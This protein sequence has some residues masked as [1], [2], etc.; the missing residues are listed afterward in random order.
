MQDGVGEVGE[1]K[2]KESSQGTF[3]FE[4]MTYD[5]ELFSIESGY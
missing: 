5:N 2:E 4:D 3:F 1:M